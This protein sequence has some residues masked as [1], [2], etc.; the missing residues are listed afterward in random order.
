MLDIV[1]GDVL[2][3]IG[4]VQ[5]LK[6]WFKP[7]Q[8]PILKLKRVMMFENWNRDFLVIF[9]HNLKNVP[10]FIVDCNK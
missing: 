10:N 6:N 2:S 3:K 8:L 1:V 7:V 9:C 5:P 4:L